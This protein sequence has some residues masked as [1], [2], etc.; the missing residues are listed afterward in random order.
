MWKRTVAEKKR[1][2][3]KNL[4]VLEEVDKYDMDRK[5][6]GEQN[7]EETDKIPVG[8]FFCGYWAFR[9]WGIVASRDQQK[10][11]FALGTIYMLF[12]LNLKQTMY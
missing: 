7:K 3:S 4:T 1:K 6:D 10:S 5:Q 2:K 9:K 12:F 8:E 11:N